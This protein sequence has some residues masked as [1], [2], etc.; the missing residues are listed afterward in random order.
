MGWI[1]NRHMSR[2]HALYDKGPKRKG[3]KR[4]GPLRKIVA[5]TSYDY[6]LFGHSTGWLECGHWSDRIYGTER[7]ICVKCKKGLP[8]DKMGK[9][10]WPL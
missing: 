4:K 3:P 7:S 9:T 2:G 10:G 1:A 6:G 8:K 5:H